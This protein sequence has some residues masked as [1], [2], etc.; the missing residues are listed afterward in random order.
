M[1]VEKLIEFENKIGDMFNN[2][3]IKA[4]IHLYN[5][6]EEKMIDIFW[7]KS[8]KLFFLKKIIFFDFLRKKIFRTKKSSA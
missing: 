2:K 7:I 8:K 5:G 4:P 6:N 3:Q 1:T